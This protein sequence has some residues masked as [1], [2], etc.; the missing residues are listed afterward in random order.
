MQS[1][2]LLYYLVL[3]HQRQLLAEAGEYRQIKE[4]EYAPMSWPQP[5][6]KSWFGVQLIKWGTRLQD[7]AITQ[8]IPAAGQTPC[9]G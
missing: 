6:L 1:T 9:S 5:S 4:A 7:R 8:S 3:E 2:I